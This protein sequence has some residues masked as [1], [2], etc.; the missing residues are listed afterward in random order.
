M[1]LT[2]PGRVCVCVMTCRSRIPPS[3]TKAILF[4][5]FRNSAISG[6]LPAPRP[7][8]ANLAR[9]RSNLAPKSTNIGPNLGQLWPEHRPTSTRIDPG[10]T[11]FARLRRNPALFRPK[12]ARTRPTSSNVGLESTNVGPN[13]TN[14]GFCRNY[15]TWGGGAMILLGRLSEQLG[16][17]ELTLQDPGSYI[18]R[19]KV[20]QGRV[21]EA[22]ARYPQTP[23]ALLPAAAAPRHSPEHCRSNLCLR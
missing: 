12:L 6:A 16:V 11:N 7:S 19:R 9:K 2:C 4:G 13:S 17:G 20:L 8:H 1:C 21:A 3:A 14:S 22:A 23:R 5:Y 18:S 10:S 15:S